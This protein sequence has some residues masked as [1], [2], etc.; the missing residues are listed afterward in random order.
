MKKIIVLCALFA[1]AH[2]TDA[3]LAT[4]DSLNTGAN[5]YYRPTTVGNHNWSD[6][7]MTFHLDVV[8]DGWGGTTWGGL[9]YSD[10]NNTT[11][12]GYTNQ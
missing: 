12:A 3:A 2:Y 7:G 8:D 1:A 9:T 10:M 4:L 6:A 11:G 5:N